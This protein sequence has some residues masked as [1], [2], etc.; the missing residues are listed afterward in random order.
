MF[1][2]SLFPIEGC[3]VCFA[4]PQSECVGSF[5]V[6]DVE[7]EVS[8]GCNVYLYEEEVGVRASMSVLRRRAEINGKSHA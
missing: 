1:T 2:F 6:L 5:F 7:H 4:H 3:N 8:H